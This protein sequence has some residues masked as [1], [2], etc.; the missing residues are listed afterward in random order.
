MDTL[1]GYLSVLDCMDDTFEENNKNAINS[2]YDFFELK[3]P[4]LYKCLNPEHGSICL[5]PTRLY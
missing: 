2:V 5:N 3:K 4:R 1:E